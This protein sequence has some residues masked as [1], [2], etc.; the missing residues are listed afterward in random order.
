MIRPNPLRRIELIAALLLSVAVLFLLFVRGTHAGALWRDECGTVQLAQMPTVSDIIE[1]FDNQTFPPMV[2]LIVRVY[3]QFCGGS[4]AAL[5]CLGLAAGVA[6]VCAAWFNARIVAHSVPLLS[7]ALF[8]LSPT[9]LTWGTTV[10]GYGFGAVLIILAFTMSAKLLLARTPFVILGAFIAILGSCQFAISNLTLAVTIGLSALLVAMIHRAF[11]TAAIVAIIIACCAL[12]GALYLKIFSSG[13]W[14]IV[15]QQSVHLSDL[16]RGFTAAYDAS[17]LSMWLVR[18]CFITSVIA[19]GWM[20]SKERS[21]H[22]T[23]NES[24]V[25][26]FALLVMVLSPIAYLAVLLLS[27]YRTKPWHYVL[28]LAL[29]AA[30]IDTISMLVSR[31]PWLRVARVIGAILAAVAAATPAWSKVHERQTNIDVVSE[32]VAE[33]AQPADLIVVAPWQYGISFNRYYRGDTPWITLPTMDDHRIHRY[34]LMLAKMISPHPID[35]VL[36]KVSQT[37]AAGNR[38]W[39]VGGVR[40]LEPG[41]APLVLPPAPKDRFGWDSAAFSESWWERVSAFVREH[42]EHGQNVSLQ[43]S[44]PVNQIEDVPLVVVDGWQ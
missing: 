26:P 25:L 7:L 31:A 1:Y 16:W 32:K 10:G 21:R 11:K 4:D 18:G 2:P 5:R 30:T 33:L 23:G 13:E 37:L 15:F 34:D 9:F 36:D 27:G 28:L 35:D 3:I 41:Q 29:L 40:T 42:G 43:S 8:G 44:R 19:G 17:P 24:I 39:L 12:I 22:L 20:L 14:R 38:V 6:F